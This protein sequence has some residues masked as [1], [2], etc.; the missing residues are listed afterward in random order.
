MNSKI[1]TTDQTCYPPIWRR[2]R[3][4]AAATDDRLKIRHINDFVRVKVEAM[5]I[6]ISFIL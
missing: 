4:A 5:S 2:R 1:K 3:P 6:K